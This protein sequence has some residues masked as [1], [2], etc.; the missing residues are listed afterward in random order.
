MLQQH[1]LMLELGKMKLFV[2]FKY[3]FFLFFLRTHPAVRYSKKLAFNKKG[4]YEEMANRIRAKSKL[5]KLQL[6]ISQIAKKT[7]IAVENKVTIIQPKKF[8]VCRFEKFLFLY[9]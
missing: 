9:L 4:K 8:F 6:E 3:F 1:I 7:G 5:E 2:L